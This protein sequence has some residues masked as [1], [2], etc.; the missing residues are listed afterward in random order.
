[1]ASEF[2]ERV[3]ADHYVISADGKHANPDPPTLQML[4]E[5]RGGDEYTIHLTNLPGPPHKA[6]KFFAEDRA[7]ND[8]KYEVVVR[9]PGALSLRV[10]L[11]EPLED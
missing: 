9:E 6:K 7:A 5:A 10:E 8:R 2:F 1:V 11:G 3:T 4:T